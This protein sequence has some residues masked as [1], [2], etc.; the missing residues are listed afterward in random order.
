MIPIAMPLLLISDSFHFSIFFEFRFIF[1]Y[2]NA[3]RTAYAS[4]R[5]HIWD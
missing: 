5:Q 4:R 3:G 1:I 2:Y